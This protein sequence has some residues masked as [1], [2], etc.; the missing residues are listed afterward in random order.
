MIEITDDLNFSSIKPLNEAIAYSSEIILPGL[1]KDI[2]KT[3]KFLQSLGFMIEDSEGNIKTLN[4]LNQDE[5]QKLS[6]AIIEYATL[7]LS[8]DPSKII[9]KLIIKRYL[10]KNDFGYSS[11]YDSNEFSSILNAC[12]RMNNASLG[13]AVMMG[14][15]KTFY[16]QI[17]DI[18]K[19]Y[20]SSI[21]QSLLWIKENEKI[22]QKDYIQYFFGE[23][24]IPENIIG[25]IASILIFDNS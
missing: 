8:I 9:D 10:I 23:D 4:N 22:Q 13:I 7:K 1:S 3:L 11:L 21:H 19:K 20:R 5:K 18:V 24:F 17:Q 25:V 14:D 6:S 16:Q 12:G 2:N 15:R